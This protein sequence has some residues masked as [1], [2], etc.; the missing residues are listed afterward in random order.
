VRLE[1][2]AATGRHEQ[3][4]RDLRIAPFDRERPRGTVV[5]RPL[6]THAGAQRDAVGLQGGHHRRGGLLV[7]LGQDV[8]ERLQ[9][10]DP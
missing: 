10:R 9:R 3:L 5:A 7:L 2:R 8:G 1:H 6:D 4:V